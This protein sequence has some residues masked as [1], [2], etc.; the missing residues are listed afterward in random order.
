MKN[1]IEN[2]YLQYM[3]SYPHKTA[4]SCVGKLDIEKYRRNLEAQ[5]VSL[6]FHIPFCETKCGY[7]N[8]F[9]VPAQTNDTIDNYISSI[10]RHSK[11]LREKIDFS[12]TNYNSLVFGGGTP[13]I[14]DKNQLEILFDIA[15]TDF[16]INLEKVYTVIETSP[17]QT[18]FDKLEYLKLKKVNRISIGVQSFVEEELLSLKRFHSPKEAEKAIEDIKKLNFNSFNIDL[19]YGIAGQTLESLEF[20]LRKALS[21]SPD[22]LFIYP[23]YQK[24]NTGIFGRFEI[25][26]KL[27]YDMYKIVV[28]ILIEEGYHQTSMRRFVKVKPEQ[29]TSCG[30]EN[31]IGLGCGGRSYIGNLHFCETYTSK[32]LKIIENIKKYNEKKDFFSNISYYKLNEDE[33]KRRFVI[34][35]ILQCQ[36]VATDEY[37]EN[38]NSEILEDFPQ[39]KEFIM[40]KWLEKSKNRIQLTD[41]GLSLSDYIGPKLMSNQVLEKMECYQDE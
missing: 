41:L 20:S 10:K 5:E 17:N 11:Q 33:I 40:E 13:L 34:K 25:D 23:L 31:M 32:S 14:L 9:S 30:F 37:F 15:E 29:S 8:L 24:V 16:N 28:K 2:P 3:Y 4:Y 12:K 35:N 26:R 18:D 7:C 19:I 27:Q 22:E 1:N 38:F 6:Y 39:L 21:Y 36:G